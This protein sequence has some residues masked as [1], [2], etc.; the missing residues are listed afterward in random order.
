MAH[1][2]GIPGAKERRR[3]AVQQGISA[4]LTNEQVTRERVEALEKRSEALIMGMR[5]MLDWYGRSFWGRL[6]WLLTGK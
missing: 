3:Q 4:A 1:L 6:R 5:T 2:V